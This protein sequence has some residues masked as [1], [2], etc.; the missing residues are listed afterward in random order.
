[1][2]DHLNEANESTHKKTQNPS[3]NEKNNTDAYSL[4]R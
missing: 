4:L 2:V 3:E 1:M